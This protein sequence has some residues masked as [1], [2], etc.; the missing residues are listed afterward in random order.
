MEK[1]RGR[2]RDVGLGR[3]SGMPEDEFISGQ[4]LWLRARAR[5]WGVK[6]KIRI[7]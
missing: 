7:D 5:R 2:E 3:E 4:Q 1:M 6:G